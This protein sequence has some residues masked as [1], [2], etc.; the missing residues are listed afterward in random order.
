MIKVGVVDDDELVRIGICDW[1]ASV[2]DFSVVCQQ[3]CAEDMF[4]SFEEQLPDVVIVDVVLP[5]VSGIELVRMARERYP[6][7]KCVLLSGSRAS[8]VLFDAFAVGAFGFLPKK[9]D[10]RELEQAVRVVAAGHHYLSPMMTEQFIAQALEMKSKLFS[11]GET[12]SSREDGE[13]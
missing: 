11:L 7:L 6:K 13:S 4:R 2:E 9:I 5:G 1:L 3:S 10:A 12:F 8:E